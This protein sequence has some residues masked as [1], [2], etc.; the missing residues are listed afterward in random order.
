MRWQDG[1]PVDFGSTDGA[2]SAR[3][4]GIMWV[5]NHPQKPFLRDYVYHD[6]NGPVYRRHPVEGNKYK[7]SRDQIAPLFAGLYL[8][9]FQDI[10]NPNYNPP[11]GDYIS[12]SVRGHFKRCSGEPDTWL[13]RMWLYLD[14][15]YSAIIDPLAE[16]NQLICMLMVADVRYLR[17][18][19]ELN[20]EWEISITKYWNGWRGEP[21][22]AELMIKTIKEKIS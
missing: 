4:A 16:S 9:N 13:E 18:W 15:V 6:N 2:D 11:N 10:V 3:L 20:D 17:M 1:Y 19:C 8:S 12:P 22:L 14:V 5:A 7:I 21:E